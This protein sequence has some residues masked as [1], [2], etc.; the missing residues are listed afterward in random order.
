MDTAN[1]TRVLLIDADCFRYIFAWHHRERE[2][3]EDLCRDIRIRVD[4]LLTLAG[5]RH[6]I[7]I[8]GSDCEWRIRNYRFK[9]YKGNRSAEKP[10]FIQKWG[11]TIEQYCMEELGFMKMPSWEADD[12]LA[13]IAMKKVDGAD[14]YSFIICSPDKDLQQIP[15]WHLTWKDTPEHAEGTLHEVSFEAAQRK[16][17]LQMLTGDS[18]D[19]VA[20]VPGLGD[21]KAEVIIASAEDLLDMELKVAEAYRKYFGEFYG[22]MIMDETRKALQMGPDEMDICINLD[23]GRPVLAYINELPDQTQAKLD[24]MFS[25]LPNL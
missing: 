21:K 14:P 24:D 15:G 17:W 13:R 18:T 6:Y 23:L 7:G 20:G 25:D 4:E 2:S 5:T 1:S 16:F 3:V 12:L 22:P 9:P 11:P 10:D 8:F 19:N